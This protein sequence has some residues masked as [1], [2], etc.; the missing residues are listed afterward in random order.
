MKLFDWIAKR[1]GKPT[2]GEMDEVIQGSLE[3]SNFKARY[4]E[5]AWDKILDKNPD[6][7]RMLK[8]LANKAST[9]EHGKK[10]SEVLEW[11]HENEDRLQ[12]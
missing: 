12:K 4:S 6:L 2:S 10:L 11:L 3:L 9:S 8:E 5:K 7:R 1:R